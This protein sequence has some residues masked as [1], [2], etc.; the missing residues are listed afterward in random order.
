MVRTTGILVLAA[1]TGCTTNTAD[2]RLAYQSSLGMRTNGVALHDEG[3]I[4]HAGMAGTNCP[5]ETKNGGVTGDYQL[6]GEGEQIQDHGDS[7]LGEETVLLVLGDNVFLLEKSTGSYRHETIEVTDVDQARLFDD[8][9]VA[10]RQSGDQCEVA[11][12]SAGMV[13]GTASAACGAGLTVDPHTG[14]AFVGTRDGVTVVDGTSEVAAEAAGDLL[15]WDATTE[16]TYVA[17]AGD[18]VV[19]A[20]EADGTLR[21]QADVGSA[22]RAIADAGI[23]EAAAV[24]VEHSDGTGGVIYLDGWTGEQRGAIATPEPARSAH[25]AASGRM[26]AVESNDDVH[27]YNVDRTTLY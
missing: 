3:D 11:W 26:I 17:T 15:A 27:F 13:D 9:I 22:V 25:V 21:W 7:D 8:G 19:S 18:S 14:L 10:T 2:T 4:G 5:F 6:P 24:V 1:L 20:I 16:A 12:V 23:F